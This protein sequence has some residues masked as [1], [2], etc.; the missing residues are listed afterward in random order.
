MPTSSASIA[1]RPGS[2]I[3]RDRTD[4]RTGL[5]KSIKDVGDSASVHPACHVAKGGEFFRHRLHHQN[6]LCTQRCL[7]VNIIDEIYKVGQFQERRKLDCRH[8][9]KTL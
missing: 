3:S 6:I 8:H 2:V 4:K 9:P 5:G 7:K 1:A